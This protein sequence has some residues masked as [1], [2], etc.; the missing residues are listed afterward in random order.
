MSAPV[1]HQIGTFPVNY[2]YF[3]TFSGGNKNAWSNYEYDY[4]FHGLK[5]SAEYLIELA[6]NEKITVAT[7]CNLSNY[8]E[9]SQNIKYKYARYLERSSVD[10]DYGLFGVNYIHP[11]LLK[12]GNW[13]STEIIKTFYQAGNPVVVLLKR[14]DKL[15]IQGI[16]RYEA[17]DFAEAQVLLEK[18]IDSDSNNVWIYSQLAKNSMKQNDFESFNR[19]LQKGREIYPLYEPFYLLEAQYLFD[20]NEFREAKVVLNELIEINPRY[21]NAAPLLKAVNEKLKLDS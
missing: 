18:A 13:Q 5:K 8:F 10:W 2:V 11:D 7:N 6:G 16:Q 21:G 14:K 15:D 9:K 17:G 3:N 4:Y 20:K 1:K 12:N 19:Y